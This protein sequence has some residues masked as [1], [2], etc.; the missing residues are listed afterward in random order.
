MHLYFVIPPLLQ[1]V[2]RGANFSCPGVKISQVSEN[3]QVTDSS[4][5][6]LSF[7][8]CLDSVIELPVKD[9]SHKSKHDLGRSLP[10]SS[11]SGVF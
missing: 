8:N 10:L 7:K 2:F 6:V 4:R 9:I 1:K 5:L 3:F 11:G